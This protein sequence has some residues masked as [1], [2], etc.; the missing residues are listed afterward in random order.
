MSEALS[1]RRIIVAL[2]VPDRN[3]AIQL[4]RLL[5]DDVAMVKI[6]LEGFVGHGPDLVREIRDMGVDIFLDLKLHDIPRTAAAAA[7]QASALGVR[8][9][10]IHAQGGAEMIRA[11]RDE[12]AA[13]T[14]VLAVTL[15]TSFDEAGVAALGY[16]HGVRATAGHLGEL[17]MTSGAD[18]LVCSPHELQALSHL[19]GLRV[20][21]GIRPAGQ[22][23]KSDDQK[24][25]ATPG[26]TID[27]GATWLV[28][29]RPIVQAADPLAALQAI[30][31]ELVTVSRE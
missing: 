2:D 5:K 16:P 29:G 30:N 13:Q 22:Q 8:L 9:L 23:T 18:G 4:C 25:T 27:A 6:G 10:T 24:R 31:A 20:V 21:P 26:A 3:G 1:D 28:V 7:A 12:T 14:S 11:V 15:L 19:P 17:A